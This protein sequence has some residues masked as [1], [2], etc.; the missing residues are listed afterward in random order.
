MRLG[1][2]WAIRKQID[3]RR[4][5]NEENRALQ[6]MGN[7]D[8]TVLPTD[9]KQGVVEHLRGRNSEVSYSVHNYVNQ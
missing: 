1:I 9:Y 4:T 3:L 6:G 8:V 7:I 5:S 2:L